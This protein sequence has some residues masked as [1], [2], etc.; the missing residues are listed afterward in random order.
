M[1]LGGGIQLVYRPEGGGPFQGSEAPR[2]LVSE[3][4]SSQREKEI[5]KEEKREGVNE[6][7]ETHMIFCPVLVSFRVSP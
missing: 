7:D 6:G 5:K 1:V 2:S 3:A 4:P